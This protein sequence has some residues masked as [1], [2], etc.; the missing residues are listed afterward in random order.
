MYV[1]FKVNRRLQEMKRDNHG[2]DKGLAEM[3]YEFVDFKTRGVEVDSAEANELVKRWQKFMTE[4]YYECTDELLEALGAMY[5]GDDFK[6]KI[7][8]FGEGT[9]L[10][11]S[12]M[13][14]AYCKRN[15]GN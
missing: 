10:Y 7:D 2:F 6:G 11:M 13:I 3:V 15:K 14:L 8:V 1:A 12:R 5:A 4:N 9:A